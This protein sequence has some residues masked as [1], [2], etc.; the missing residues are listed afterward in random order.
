MSCIH[1]KFRSSLE[2]DT[3][4]FDGL[5]ISLADL[6]KA[7]MAQKKFGKTTDFDLEI[8]N[9]QTKEVYKDESVQIPKNSSVI[10]RRIPTGTRSKSQLAA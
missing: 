9:A 6:K 8:T 5:G 1:Y 4:T 3:V 2:Y 10:I 7:I